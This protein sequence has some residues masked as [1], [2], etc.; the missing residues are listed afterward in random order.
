[1]QKISFVIP[2]YNSEKY[3]EKTITALNAVITKKL[4][5]YDSEIILINDFSKDNTFNKIEKLS[6]INDNIISIDLAKNFG[7]HNAIMAGLKYAKGDIIICL[8]DDGQTPP[9]ESLKLIESLDDKTDVV[10]GKYKIKKHNLFRNLGSYFNDYISCKILNKPKELYIS[11][12][13]A[14]KKYI[15]DEIIKYDNPYPYLAGLI[16]RTT[17]NIKNVILSHKKREIGESNYSFKKLLR[18]WL[19]GFT[20]FSVKPLRIAIIFSV[21]FIFIAIITTIL[22][23]RNK[24]LNPNVPLGWSSMVVVVLLVGASITF[25]LGLIGEYVGRI[26]I[27]INNNPQYV[28]RKIIKKENKD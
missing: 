23:I 3:I 10:Y 17:G 11:S 4:Y 24:I 6:E 27:S 14:M 8:D 28:I 26:Y 22:I 15:K 19:N 5:D 20:N 25:I 1:M 2:C 18:L 16:L 7:Q 21:L 9:E 12:Y 13:F